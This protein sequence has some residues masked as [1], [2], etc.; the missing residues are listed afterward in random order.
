[1]TISS[2]I[3]F[4]RKES[5]FTL[6][7]LTVVLFIVALLLGGLLP[8]ISGQMEQARRNETRKQLE[9][10]QMA[11][12]GF[13]IIN[14]RLPCPASA[15][16]NGIESPVGGGLCTNFYNGFV[17]AVTLGLST[18]DG[19]G[20]ALDSWGN[21]IHY[22]VTSAN[23]TNVFTTPNGMSTTGISSLSPDLLVCSTAS[24]SNSSCSVANSSLTS[25]GVP[26]VIYSTG[27][28]GGSGGSGTDESENPNI[29]SADNDRVFA[30]HTPTPASAVNG[31]FDDIV[32]WISQNTLINRMVTAG[33]LP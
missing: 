7:E 24:T 26:A 13:A 16:S 10:I 29:N 12:I 28:N 23:G 31:E 25:P 22:A 30:S 2:S 19:S 20:F 14:G 6:I 17:P 1:M 32:F 4:D 33:K 27:M 18:F 11:L 15:A 3:L 5:G 21:R 9:E 8:T